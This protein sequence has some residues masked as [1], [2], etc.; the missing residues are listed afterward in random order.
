[1]IALCRNRL[2][3]VLGKLDREAN[4]ILPPNICEAQSRGLGGG[5]AICKSSGCFALMPRVD[6]NLVKL[7]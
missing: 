4:N 7:P 3:E 5:T 6:R 1:M 2:G